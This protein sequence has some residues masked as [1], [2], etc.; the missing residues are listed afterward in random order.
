MPSHVRGRLQSNLP[1]K[2]CYAGSCA[3]D[4]VVIEDWLIVAVHQL[5]KLGRLPQVL[6]VRVGPDLGKLLEAGLHC[7]VQ[8]L[9]PCIHLQGRG[10]SD[11]AAG[12][13]HTLP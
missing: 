4:G 3:L 10:S 2:L 11:A 8:C 9:Q 1:K 12:A 5:L 13:T 6:E 7:G